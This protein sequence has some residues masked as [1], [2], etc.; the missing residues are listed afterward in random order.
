MKIQLPQN[1]KYIIDKLYDN[2]FEAYAVGGCVRDSL[3]GV[4]PKDWDITTNALPEDVK[5]IFSHTIDT[6]IKH[7]TVS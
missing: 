2:G 7:G 4:E 6:G 1:V 5:K 3:M